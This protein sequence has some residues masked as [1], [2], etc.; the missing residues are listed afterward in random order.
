[1]SIN[2]PAAMSGPIDE[3]NGVLTA[4]SSEAQNRANSEVGCHNFVS[5]YLD[6]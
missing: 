1:M 5:S 3:L 6:S 2:L 4:E